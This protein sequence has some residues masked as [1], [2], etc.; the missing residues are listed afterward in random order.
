MIWCSTWIEAQKKKRVS[1][2]G[3][4]SMASVMTTTGIINDDHIIF[5]CFL[6]NFRTRAEGVKVAYI[7][8]PPTKRATTA[9]TM[10]R[11][12]LSTLALKVLAVG[13][14]MDSILSR[15]R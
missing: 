2:S 7:W 11:D 10:L 15:P 8:G 6:A 1:R 12:R 13:R 3:R 5:L 14:I 4:L 9:L